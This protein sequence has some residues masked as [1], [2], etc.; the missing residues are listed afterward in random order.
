MCGNSTLQMTMANGRHGQAGR[1]TGT[2]RSWMSAG[3]EACD[4]EETEH[5][6]RVRKER[7]LQDSICAGDSHIDHLNRS[8]VEGGADDH[9]H[10]TAETRGGTECRRTAKLR[11]I[12]ARAARAAA[13]GAERCVCELHAC[14]LAA[15]GGIC[16]INQN[17]RAYW[18]G[19]YNFSCFIMFT[20][21]SARY[22]RLSEKFHTQRRDQ[23][24]PNNRDV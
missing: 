17:Y 20:C 24:F 15:G 13:A 2:S 12:H 11:A 14:F 21:M 8:A 6:T 1:I 19:R 9:R 16:L 7:Q 18:V 22:L 3:L 5:R 10:P 23:Y 4:I